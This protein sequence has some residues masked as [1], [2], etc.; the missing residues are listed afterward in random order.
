MFQSYPGR[1]VG[2]H[3][4][5]QRDALAHTARLSRAGSRLAAAVAAATVAL[6][7]SAAI[8]AAFAQQT[9]ATVHHTAGGDVS[10]A[11]FELFRNQGIIG[12]NHEFGHLRALV[13]WQR[14]NLLDDFLCAHAPTLHKNSR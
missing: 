5:A 13:R 7:A 4:H 6:L 3:R 10:H 9:Q 11:L 12:F 2:L 14:L 1:L 8:P